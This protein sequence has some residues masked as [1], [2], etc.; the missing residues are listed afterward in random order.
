MY[1]YKLCTTY[2]YNLCFT[3]KILENVVANGLQPHILYSHLSDPLQSAY[4]LH[5]SI[6]SALLKVHNGIIISIDKGESTTVTLLDFQLLSTKKLNILLTYFLGQNAQNIYT[7]QIQ[8]DLFFTLKLR[9]G[10]ELYL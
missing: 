10:Q 2:V 1:V 5:H 3:S 4:R 8:I 9:L 6:E 7:P